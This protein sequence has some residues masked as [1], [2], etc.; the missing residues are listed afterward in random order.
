MILE[1]NPRSLKSHTIAICLK[2]SS[3]AE[4]KIQQHSPTAPKPGCLLLYCRF[5]LFDTAELLPAALGIA[6]HTHTRYAAS[7]L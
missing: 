2:S 6:L 1:E 3:G 5:C 7:I 4:Y